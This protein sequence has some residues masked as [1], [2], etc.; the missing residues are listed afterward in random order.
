MHLGSIRAAVD[1]YFRPQ[2]FEQNGKLY[3]WLG[4]RSFKRLMVALA[5]R[6]RRRHYLLQGRS[7]QHVRAF[8]RRTKSN[9]LVHL[10]GVAGPALAILLCGTGNTIATLLLLLV[11]IANLY[12]FLLQRYNRV[13]LLRTIRRMES[14][15]A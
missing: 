8:E 5:H 15:Q 3:G 4:M 7:I 1:R 11:L 13:R 9:E 2:A 12:P 6:C 14:R 10:L